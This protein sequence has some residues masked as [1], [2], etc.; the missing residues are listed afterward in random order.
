MAPYQWERT[1]QYHNFTGEEQGL[2]GSKAYA[3]HADSIGVDIRGYITLDIVGASED[4]E[5]HVDTTRV[6]TFADTTAFSRSMQRYMKRIGE[7][8]VPDLEVVVK[9]RP[10]RAGRGSDHL[11]FSDNGYTAIRLIEMKENLQHQHS[12]NDVLAWLRPTYHARVTRLAL[13]CLA[14][15][16]QA[17][18]TPTGVNTALTPG[19]HLEIYWS[20]NSESDLAGYLVGY[21]LPD[22]VGT[23]DDSSIVG[24]DPLTMVDVGLV[25]S[26]ILVGPA[27][28]DSIYVA[29]AAR[30]TGGHESIAS[31]ELGRVMPQATGV[32]LTSAESGVA[33]FG[34]GEPRPNPSSGTVE[35]AMA[36]SAGR[37]AGDLAVYDLAG[38]RVATLY[39]GEL[40]AGS[41]SVSWD[42][43]DQRGARVPAG[44]YFIRLDAAGESLA[45]KVIVTP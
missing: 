37:L 38:R 45:R 4:A 1:I 34:L 39:R 5:G 43:H 12:A 28:G 36:L 6:R 30:D 14:N 7:A 23:A 9:P 27:T 33:I 40:P 26:H 42:L 20:A 29:V 17:P 18:A 41:R 22:P 35:I 25:T 13:A 31:R 15:L 10:D 24:G 11:G 16:A 44:V 8:Y 19:G 32:P 21:H 3:S 2:L